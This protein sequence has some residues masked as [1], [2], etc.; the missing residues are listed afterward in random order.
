MT[1]S[2]RDAPNDPGR[3]TRIL[4]AALDVVAD[5]GVNEATH[6][7]IAARA[8]VPLGSLTYYFDGIDDLL[9]RAFARLADEMSVVYRAGLERAAD[10]EAAQAAVVDLICGPG[11]ATDRELTLIWEMYAYANH[12]TAVARTTR[13]WLARSHASLGLHFPPETCAALDVLVEGW[14]MHRAFQGRPLDRALVATT[15]RAI[16]AA[17]APDAG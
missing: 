10:A 9:A 8:G 11:Y 16:V 6:R 3:E 14:P 4:D 15:V 2:R 5:V 12:N 1:G 17:H 7:K 13:E